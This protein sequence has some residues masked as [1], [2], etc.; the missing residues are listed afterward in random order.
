MKFKKVKAIDVQVGDVIRFDGIEAQVEQIA[1]KL[2]GMS[3][4]LSFA[5]EGV[6]VIKRDYQFIEKGV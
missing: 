4:I 1:A 5:V 3:L 6:V 2:I